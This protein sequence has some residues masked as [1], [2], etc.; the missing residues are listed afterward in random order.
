MKMDRTALLAA[1]EAVKP[2]LSNRNMIEELACIWFDGEALT[3]F[4]DSSLGIRVPFECDLKGGLRGSVLL[5]LLTHSRAKEIE[6]DLAAEGEATLKAAKT[7]LKLALLN[8]SRAVYELPSL[9]KGAKHSSPDKG[10]RE[11]LK[12]V[13]ISLGNSSVAPDQMGVILISR[14]GRLHFFTTDEKTIASAS[15]PSKEWPLK[16]GERIIVPTDFINEYIKLADKKEADTELYI[17]PDGITARFKSGVLLFSKLV[18]NPKA[19]D[20]FGIITKCSKGYPTFPIPDR[21]RMGLDKVSV[22]LAGQT[23]DKISIDIDGDHMTLSADT[24]LG[25]IED[26]I[27]ID[28]APD[29]IEFNMIPDLIKRALDQCDMMA[30]SEDNTM[31]FG[32]NFKYIIANYHEAT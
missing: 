26:K 10:F 1:I 29:P 2:A 9:G 8:V 17:T 16:E 7:T 12:A 15:I 27:K 28:D 4:N 31:M 6:I 24:A 5:G 30:V 21:M 32:E 20:F 13:S 18:D 3:A 11:A 14:A 22:L 23:N 25:S 19:N